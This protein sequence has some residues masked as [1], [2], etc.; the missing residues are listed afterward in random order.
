VQMLSSDRYIQWPRWECRCG[1]W[2]EPG[3]NAGRPKGVFMVM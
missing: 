3:G 2:M 1:M